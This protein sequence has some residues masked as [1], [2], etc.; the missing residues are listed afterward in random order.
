MGVCMQSFPKYDN[1]KE[2]DLK[3]LTKPEINEQDVKN[4]QRAFKI[5]DEDNKGYIQYDVDK[6]KAS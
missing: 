5:L 4:L 2:V 3:Y 6:I 1:D